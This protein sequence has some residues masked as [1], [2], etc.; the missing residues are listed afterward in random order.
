MKTVKDFFTGKE[1][2]KIAESHIRYYCP[3]KCE[4]DKTYNAQGNCPECNMNLVPVSK[5]SSHDHQHNHGCC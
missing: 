4:G 2:E 5:T 1:E 3:M